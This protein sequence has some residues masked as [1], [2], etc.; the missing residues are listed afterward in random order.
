MENPI[1]MDDWGVPLFLE[2]P[3]CMFF[4]HVFFFQS[5]FCCGEIS[6]LCW[7]A[8]YGWDQV[9][10]QLVIAEHKIQNLSD[11]VAGKWKGQRGPFL[12]RSGFLCRKNGDPGTKTWKTWS[13]I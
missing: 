6:L 4:G 7:G 9:A 5:E 8:I 13:F 1:K 2:T 12:E 11:S 3:I 10:S